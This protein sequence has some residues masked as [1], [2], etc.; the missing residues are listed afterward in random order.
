MKKLSS[1]AAQHLFSVLLYM[2]FCIASSCIIDAGIATDE[3]NDAVEVM[4]AQERP[5]PASNSGIADLMT[6]HMLMQVQ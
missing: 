3:L 2:I 1:L 5:A 6:T 4:H